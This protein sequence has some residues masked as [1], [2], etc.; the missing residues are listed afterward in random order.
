MTASRVEAGVKS[1]E[2]IGWGGFEVRLRFIP[3]NRCF[4][5][6]GKKGCAQEVR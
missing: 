4:D 3:S 5:L 1:P 6:R 2:E